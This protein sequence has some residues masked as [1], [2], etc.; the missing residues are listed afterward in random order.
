[1]C[2]KAKFL[3]SGLQ[4]KPGCSHHIIHKPQIYKSILESIIYLLR[5]IIYGAGHIT[6]QSHFVCFYF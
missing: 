5:Y 2:A 1:M 6:E 3:N 4:H